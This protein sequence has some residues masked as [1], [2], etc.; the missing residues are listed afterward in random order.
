M[1]VWV[2]N[3]RKDP[4]KLF[5]TYRV[6]ALAGTLGQKEWKVITR[7]RKDFIISMN[8]ILKAIIIYHLGLN[9]PNISDRILSDIN[10][11]GGDIYI[12][13]SCVT[14]GCIPLTDP[15][16]EELYI[17]AAHAKNQGQDFIPVHIFPI[18]F[19]VKRSVDYLGR[20]TKDDEQLKDFHLIL[21]MPLIILKSISKCRL[22]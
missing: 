17:I 3:D 21:K 8:S 22:L 15:M 9:Y 13:G 20:L 19:N 18:R 16:I 12:H 1:E 7:C 11:P 6:C 4:Y 5:K 14:V 2:K 10:S